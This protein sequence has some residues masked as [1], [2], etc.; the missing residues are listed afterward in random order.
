MTSR[1]GRSVGVGATAAVER[2]RLLWRWQR[3]A[4]RRVHARNESIVLITLA[5]AGARPLSP[6]NAVAGA[7]GAGFSDASA[8]VGARI[9]LG[10]TKACVPVRHALSVRT[11]AGNLMA[12][13]ATAGSAVHRIAHRVA[14]ALSATGGGRAPCARQATLAS[15]RDASSADSP[16][17]QNAAARRCAAGAECAPASG[18]TFTLTR[19]AGRSANQLACSPVRARARGAGCAG[20]RL[21]ADVRR[22]RASETRVAGAVRIAGATFSPCLRGCA[23]IA[24]A[25]AASPRSEQDSCQKDQSSN[26]SHRFE[27][28]HGPAGRASRLATLGRPEEVFP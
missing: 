6:R 8:I 19:G 5:C 10:S 26:V 22:G 21:D 2:R 27:A 28:F 15:V 20:A 12:A 4:A 1:K 13:H 18:E 17:G 23:D 25:A 14:A 24:I 16:S 9:E 7:R 3:I 11:R